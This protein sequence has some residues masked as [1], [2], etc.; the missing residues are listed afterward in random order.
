M[1][2]STRDPRGRDPFGESFGER[3]EPYRDDLYRDE[4]Y[5]DE[6][7]WLDQHDPV[8]DF[9]RAQREDITPLSA[10]DLRPPPPRPS[11]A[12]WWSPSRA[13]SFLTG[14][15]RWPR[16]ATPRPPRWGNGSR[17]ASTSEP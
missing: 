17:R 4:P 9:F 12:V 14:P 8:D 1:S 16:R 10:D 11:S 13:A 3:G 5:R 15:P 2:P 7:G 6:D